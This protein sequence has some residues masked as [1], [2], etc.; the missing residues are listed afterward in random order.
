MP[1]Q[2]AIE[3]QFRNWPDKLQSH[4]GR[5]SKELLSGSRKFSSLT[6][7]EVVSE[8]W[9]PNHNGGE[10]RKVPWREKETKTDFLS[11]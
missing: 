3:I 9:K 2:P 10:S 4:G 7:R 11:L 8:L 6:G 5:S 1:K